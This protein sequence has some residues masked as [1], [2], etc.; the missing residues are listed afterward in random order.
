[1]SQN[2]D[3]LA[4]AGRGGPHYASPTSR[5]PSPKV[6]N[7]TPPS[8]ERGPS[9]RQISPTPD[10]YTNP[11]R[12]RQPWKD[13]SP[14]RWQLL[15]N[16]RQSWGLSPTAPTRHKR[17]PEPKPFFRQP[18]GGATQVYGNHQPGSYRDISHY[19][20]PSMVEDPWAA[21]QAEAQYR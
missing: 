8:L 6:W 13:W 11:N 19:Y 21:L 16:Q 14:G 2:L 4:L 1:M 9:E 18:R 3:F 20:S 10:Q 12:R 7:S 15:Q 5:H 17:T